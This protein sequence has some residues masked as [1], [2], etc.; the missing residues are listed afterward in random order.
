[1][2]WPDKEVFYLEGETT[3]EELGRVIIDLTSV[4]KERPF[5]ELGTWFLQIEYI[6]FAGGQRQAN[7]GQ[8]ANGV[9][10]NVTAENLYDSSNREPAILALVHKKS[11]LHRAVFFSAGDP[12][13]RRIIQPLPRNCDR[14]A[15]NLI[16][17]QTHGAPD[18]RVGER[19]PL[20]CS[21]GISI[22]IPHRRKS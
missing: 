1:M 5:L 22:Q 14:I 19:A 13:C 10:F 6:Y 9:C 21:I 3:P 18:W 15:L 20:E 11:N 17:K 4:T 8:R 12:E 16:T 2:S 7:A